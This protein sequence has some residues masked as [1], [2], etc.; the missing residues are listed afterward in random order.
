MFDNQE[1]AR[2]QQVL[3]AKVDQI[4]ADLDELEKFIKGS[5]GENSAMA[6]LE[7]EQLKDFKLFVLSTLSTWDVQPQERVLSPRLA[8]VLNKKGRDLSGTIITSELCL[9]RLGEVLKDEFYTS[10][11]GV[12]NGATKGRREAFNRLI[13]SLHLRPYLR[14]LC[15][16]DLRAKYLDPQD[17]SCSSDSFE[18]L[19]ILFSQK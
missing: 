17:I 1:V 18:F 12:M 16:S 4:R 14:S 9:P 11:R 10:V 3:L 8:V 19:R 13:Y 6:I 15:I 7:K 2:N 5:C